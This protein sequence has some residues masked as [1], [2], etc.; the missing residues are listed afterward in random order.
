MSEYFGTMKDNGDVPIVFIPKRSCWHPFILVP[1]GAYVLVQ[2]GGRDVDFIDAGSVKRSIWPPGLHWA[3]PFPC[4]QLRI[5][6]IV[7][8]QTFLFYSTINRVLTK[9][10]VSVRISASVSLRVMGDSEQGEDDELVRRF[11]HTLGPSELTLQLKDALEENIRFLARRVLHKNVYQLCSLSKQ[12]KDD[13]DNSGGDA[14]VDD[15]E[16]SS[17]RIQRRST[18]DLYRNTEM[19]TSVAE[20]VIRSGGRMR[21]GTVIRVGEDLQK[22]LCDRR[23]EVKE[24]RDRQHELALRKHEKKRKKL[25]TSK[26]S[27][28]QANDEEE[29][30]QILRFSSEK[31]KSSIVEVE[32]KET[33]N[34]IEIETNR[35]SKMNGTEEENLGK[36]YDNLDAQDEVNVNVK[37]ALHAKEKKRFNLKLEKKRLAREEEKKK[38]NLNLSDRLRGSGEKSRIHP[39]RDECGYAKI[40]PSQ[41]TSISSSQGS[42]E[43]NYKNPIHLI[44]AKLNA[45][46]KSYGIEIIQVAVQN[47]DLPT[48]LAALMSDKTYQ[49][50]IVE[51]QK[52]RHQ[53]E[54]Q[55]VRHIERKAE[56]NQLNY[57]VQ[58]LEK[59]IGLHAMANVSSKLNKIKADTLSMKNFQE[60]NE[61]ADVRSVMAKSKL[62]VQK[63]TSER[64]VLL[65]HF[66]AKANSDCKILEAEVDGLEIQKL[67]DA[68]LKDV[69]NRAI[70]KEMLATVEGKYAEKLKKKRLH[71]LSLQ[72]LQFFRNLSEHNST[73]T[74]VGEQEFGND[75][76]I[77]SDF[78]IVSQKIIPKDSCDIVITL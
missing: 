20:A 9:D 36:I 51:E 13:Y 73:I 7:P 76:K 52:M 67:A 62:F 27:F 34:M 72:Q 14:I 32:K 30:Y 78:Q 48:N 69:R 38:R 35:F 64:E 66:L 50:I 61:E 31:V 39:N 23:K 74:I 18:I 3:S 41:E 42:T 10:N 37:A 11:V 12:R 57:N 16:I 43:K 19:Q 63:L 60:V 2:S 29:K 26:T 54:M 45:Q 49:D 53:Y 4:N 5:S 15:K 71:L 70:G 22:Q 17:N 8:K 28:V 33:E 75:K 46:F 40:H 1:S 56:M 6:H 25:S 59:K 68:V 21:R 58:K 47:I 65:I 55:T 24:A 77:I 44:H